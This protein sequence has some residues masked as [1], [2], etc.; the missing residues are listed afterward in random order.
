MKKMI[1]I[2]LFPVLASADTINFG[3]DTPGTVPKGWSVNMTHPGGA[4]KW[5]VVA[6]KNAPSKKPY[7]VGQ[8]SK[9]P[10]DNRFPLLILDNSNLKDGEVSVSFKA[11]SGKI[12]QGA[13]VVWRY[14]DPNTY[15]I[16]S[17]NE[18]EDNVVMYKLERDITRRIKIIT[19]WRYPKKSPARGAIPMEVLLEVSSIIGG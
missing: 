9:S 14:K 19:A 18:L 11:I 5:E 13:G 2:L 3:S 7:V 12:D 15:Y 16:A 17:A 6:D 8:T 4:P 10:D 1:L